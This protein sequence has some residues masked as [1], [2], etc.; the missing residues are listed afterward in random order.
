M[1]I[2]FKIFSEFIFEGI[3]LQY[4]EETGGNFLQVYSDFLKFSNFRPC[5]LRRS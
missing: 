3:F 1:V 4:G 2:V 5:F